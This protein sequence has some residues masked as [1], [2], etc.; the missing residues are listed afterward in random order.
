MEERDQRNERVRDLEIVEPECCVQGQSL[1][2][3]IHLFMIKTFYNYVLLI[4]LKWLFF[5]G[6]LLTQC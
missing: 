3:F 4:L 5:T 2:F 6:S 1:M